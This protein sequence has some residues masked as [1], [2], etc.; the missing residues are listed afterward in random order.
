M[1]DLAAATD[2]T[3]PGKRRTQART[4]FAEHLH[5]SGAFERG[6]VAKCQ[7]VGTGPHLRLRS[8][9]SETLQ[10]VHLVTSFSL[11]ASADLHAARTRLQSVAA[12][13]TQLKLRTQHCPRTLLPW[14]LQAELQCGTA[15]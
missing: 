8:A 14:G 11:R 15:S 1:P 4:H 5:Q 3:K 10:A 13:L 9:A 12:R 7:L 2:V 6:C